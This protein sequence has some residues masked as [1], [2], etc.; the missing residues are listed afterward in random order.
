MS[1]VKAIR[2]E[3]KLYIE[4]AD[5]STIKKLHAIIEAED[6]NDWWGN[7]SAAAKKSILR[8]EKQLEEGKGIPHEV[9][10]KKYKRWLTK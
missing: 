1:S 3:V 10:M 4:K 8:A 9:V 6:E 7:L 2:E 5:A